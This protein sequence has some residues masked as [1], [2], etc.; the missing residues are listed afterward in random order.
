M[1]EAV[2]RAEPVEAEQ[3]FGY[4]DVE[5]A[6]LVVFGVPEQRRGSIRGHIKGFQKYEIF[7][8][9]GTGRRRSYS[10]NDAIKIA[11][12]LRVHALG[13]DPKLLSS[14]WGRPDVEHGISAALAGARARIHLFR[15]VGEVGFRIVVHV[16]DVATFDDAVCVNLTKLT[17]RVAA[18]LA[19]TE[20]SDAHS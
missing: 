5:E 2:A 17:A 7:P 15:A 3:R 1:S 18:V 8:P 11:L 9:I 14:L 19:D 16:G 4:A 10:L 12:T 13:V 6:M 20:A